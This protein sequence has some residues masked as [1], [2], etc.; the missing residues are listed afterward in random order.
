MACCSTM[1]SPHS[2]LPGTPWWCVEDLENVKKA[3]EHNHR[4][5]EQLNASFTGFHLQHQHWYSSVHNRCASLEALCEQLSGSVRN[6]LVAG[7]PQQLCQEQSARIDQ[8]FAQAHQELVRETAEFNERLEQ[9]QTKLDQSLSMAA[10]AVATTDAEDATGALDGTLAMLVNIK[11]SLEQTH[12]AIAA[13]CT[14]AQSKETTATTSTMA[15]SFQP[16]TVMPVS[17][18]KGQHERTKSSLLATPKVQRRASAGE[19]RRESS[20]ASSGGTSPC[21]TRATTPLRKKPT[22][23]AL[24]TQ[25]VRQ[26]VRNTGTQSLVKGHSVAALRNLNDSPRIRPGR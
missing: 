6:L 5:I 10:G 25:P 18:A 22:R 24:H 26:A 15:S 20:C 14:E 9:L 16:A 11:E 8:M 4:S 12:Q 21:L 23:Q 2:Q 13:N 17:P 7:T 3:V 19:R 1:T